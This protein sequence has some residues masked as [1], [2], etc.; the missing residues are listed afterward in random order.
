MPAT[1]H[2]PPSPAPHAG[3]AAPVR[4]ARGVLR[5]AGWM[6]ASAVLLQGVF[7]ARIA[8]M[9]AVDPQSTAFQRSEAWRLASQG[10]GL[11]DWRQRW[12]PYEAI[13]PHLRRAVVASE[14]AGFVS[15]FGVDWAA[16][17]AARARNERRLAQTAS[18]GG[19]G[20]V[21]PARLAGGSTITQQLAK[22]LLLSGE[23]TLWR[24]GQELL[25][26][27]M[28][29]ALLDKRRILE[30]YLNAVEWGEGVF[31]AEAAA[32]RYFRKPAARL[33]PAEA[34]RLAV[35]LPAPKLYERRL[36]SG[37][38]NSRTQTILARME[39]VQIP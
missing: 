32:Q 10:R 16:I 36:Q 17:E 30:L 18:R 27:W 21:R 39:A 15:H 8:V 7:A 11:G 2:R 25:L 14:D 24:K 34:A 12:V 31:G 13:S 9:A 3:T 37:Y 4:W 5:A 38:L 35:L 22:N 23:R 19:D 33:T 1:P 6:L 20:H 26:A 28:L 29:E